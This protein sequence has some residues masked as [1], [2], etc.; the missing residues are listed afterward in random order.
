MKNFKFTIK[1]QEY[2]VAVSEAEGNIMDIDV[3]GTKYEVEIHREKKTTKT[4]TLVRKPV[5]RT[6]KSDNVK[7]SAAGS[8]VKS[9]LPGNILKV[10]VA[11]GDAVKAGDSLLIMEAMKM[12]NNVLAE[13]A[14]T[15]K[16]I[17][18]AAGD[19]VLQDDVLIELA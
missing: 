9:P 2:D 7:M 12:E 6:V 10:N 14:G 19:T 18:V 11:V 15:V 5:E 1:G 13:E 3:N 16:S 4:P 8:V 17:K